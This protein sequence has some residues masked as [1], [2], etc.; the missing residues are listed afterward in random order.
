MSC[1]P[2]SRIL[3]LFLAKARVQIFFL[4][5][6]FPISGSNTIA[7]FTVLPSGCSPADLA[8][9]AAANNP[10]NT[11]NIILAK[12]AAQWAAVSARLEAVQPLLQTL[13][14]EPAPSLTVPGMNPTAPVLWLGTP[15]QMCYVIPF[16]MNVNPKA[17][18]LFDG[19]GWGTGS[20]WYPN[21]LGANA[22]PLPVAAQD[23]VG[24]SIPATL[25]VGIYS[26]VIQDSTNGGVI[27]STTFSAGSGIVYFSSLTFGPGAL[28]L[29]VS[30]TVDA[31]HA[32]T[33]D[34]IQIIDPVG[35]VFFWFYTSCQCQTQPGPGAV[36]A[37]TGTTSFQIIL[38]GA[39]K[40]AYTPVLLPGGGSLPAMSGTDWVPWNLMGL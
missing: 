7:Y 1:K 33:Q 16:S 38:A 3:H 12:Q 36:A 28:I 32:S 9:A 26:I 39:V 37:T 14:A 11:L 22:S 5:R 35:A 29:T 20:S 18:V 24:I 10:I 31:A 19:A 23:C 17:L 27:A 8:A 30:W 15:L 13:L 40:G 21:A 6:Y 4:Y 34:L 2:C 25:S